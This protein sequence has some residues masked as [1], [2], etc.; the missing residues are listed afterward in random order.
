[1]NLSI[2]QINNKKTQPFLTTRKATE[3]RNNSIKSI[4]IDH[5]PSLVATLNE[6]DHIIK[7]VKAR[8]WHEYLKLF[9]NHSRITKEIKGTQILQELGLGVPQIYE[10]GYGIIPSLKHEYIGYYIMENLK[11][12]GF[13]EVS[14]L[15]TNNEI[16]EFSRNKIIASIF[17]GLK[18]MRE[19]NIVFSDFHLD[20]VFSNKNGE[21]VWI[22]AGVTTYRTTF[23]SKRFHIKYNDSIRRYQYYLEKKGLLSKK[24]REIFT[25]LV[26]S[27]K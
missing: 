10:I 14:N 16:N 5:K 6:S 18:K 1:M 17:T 24:E 26:F 4:L 20:N 19:N 25:K 27:I 11:N 3:H 9:W 8:S 21:V 15:I 23:S 13:T 2:F 12:N 7:F 22:D